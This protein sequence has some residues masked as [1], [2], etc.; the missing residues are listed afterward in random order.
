[1]NLKILSLA[2]TLSCFPAYAQTSAAEEA[3][4]LNQEL[5]FLE[6][7]TRATGIITESILPSSPIQRLRSSTGESL[8]DT[9]FGD[10]AESEDAVRTR[11]AAPKR[12]GQ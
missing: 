8:E 11:T 10:E 5:Q 6:D 12:R 9:Y 7:S 4:I 1:M 2:I 3:L